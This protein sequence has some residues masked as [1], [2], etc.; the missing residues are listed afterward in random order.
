[1]QPAENVLPVLKCQELSKKPVALILIGSI[2]LKPYNLSKGRNQS[3]SNTLGE[4]IASNDQSL[5]L[6]FRPRNTNTSF[7]WKVVERVEPTSFQVARDEKRHLWPKD[8]VSEGIWKSLM[9]DKQ[10]KQNR[11]Y[12]LWNKSSH[13][14]A[15]PAE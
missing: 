15:R 1:M 5:C 12:M 8:K 9:W 4:N 3:I 11:K 13:L 14:W 2:H 7:T 6:T 10:S